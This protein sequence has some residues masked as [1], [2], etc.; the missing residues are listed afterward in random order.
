MNRTIDPHGERRAQRILCARR[1]HRKSHNLSIDSALAK[2]QSLLDAILIHR[3]HHQLAV[4]QSHCTVADMYALL[5]I[6]N[7]PNER[8]YA[9]L[10]T[11]SLPVCWLSIERTHRTSSINTASAFHRHNNSADRTTQLLNFT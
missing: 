4:L 3:I 2:S 5:C 8:Q 1:P 11:P 6:E 9:H 7:L 10:Y